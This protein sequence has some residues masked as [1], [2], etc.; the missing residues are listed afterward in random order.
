MQKKV[1]IIHY[2]I[3]A[4][5]VFG[6]GFLPPFGEMTV[7]GMH[8]LGTFIGAIYG[9]STIGMIWPSLM[10]L[11][12]IGMA[13]GM[14]NMLNATFANPIVASMFTLFPLM[15]VL[16][17]LH[18]TQ[19]VVG[20]FLT[21]KLNVGHPWRMIT[22]LL[23]G[24]YVCSFI[25][26]ILLAIIFGVFVLGMCKE[27]KIAPYSKL[28]TT[29][30]IGLG[31]ALMNGQIMLPFQGTALTFMA[32]YNGM[33]QT[34]LPFGKFM[35]FTIPLGVVMTLVYV[36]IMRFVF[37]VDVSPLTNVT[38]EMLGTTKKMTRDQK[39]ASG[40]FL[41]FTVAMMGYALPQSF[42]ITQFLNELTFFGV[43]TVFVCAMMLVKDSN[44]KPLLDFGLMAA[45]GMAWDPILLTAYV[46]VISVYLTAEDTG[47]AATI[48]SLLAPMTTLPTIAFIVVIILFAVIVTNFANNLILTIVLM[49][50][51]SNFA[52]QVGLDPLGLILLT[53]TATQMALVTP[54]ASPVIG[55]MFAQTDLVKAKDMTMYAL[56]ALPFLF[57]ACMI[58]GIGLMNLIF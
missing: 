38:E 44:G 50:V 43:A 21:S 19:Y 31:Y 51:I 8:V 16:D 45:K 11:T 32:A 46:M 22:I 34:M 20:K 29:L 42:F 41:A 14:P 54:G 35:L 10:A 15:A 28:P 18:V 48:G 47:V 40:F 58:V 53:L 5:F 24:A 6:F 27:L 13:I 3:T 12:G 36:L 26:T 4:A 57:V 23:L 1:S 49:P 9:W 2:I 30:L 39:I 7:H 37:R 33:F 25:N 52:Q 56:K 17:E 55:L